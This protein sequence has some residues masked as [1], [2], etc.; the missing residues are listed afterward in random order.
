M[1]IDEIGKSN[2]I[3]LFSYIFERDKESFTLS[4]IQSEMTQ[5]GIR[6]TNEEIR[7]RVGRFVALGFV[8]QEY[9][10]YVRCDM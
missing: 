5:K 2:D 8:C 9:K 3:A 1:I 10:R 4:E 7:E 6:L